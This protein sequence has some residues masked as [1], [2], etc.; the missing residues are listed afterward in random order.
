MP[1][2]WSFE[3]NNARFAALG[4]VAPLLSSLSAVHSFR[5][6]LRSF[7]EATRLSPHPQ[8]LPSWRDEDDGIAFDLTD[9]DS[10]SVKHWRLDQGSLRGLCYAL[11]LCSHVHTLWYGIRLIE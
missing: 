11:P 9:K 4:D 3:A 5:R 6:D 1:S 8:L 10:V 7:Y 2:V